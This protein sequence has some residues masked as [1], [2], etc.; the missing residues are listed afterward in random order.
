MSTGTVQSLKLVSLPEKLSWEWIW[1]CDQAA[2]GAQAG[3]SQ[4]S[5]VRWALVAGGIPWFCSP[6]VTWMKSMFMQPENGKLF[7]WSL[8]LVSIS[9]RRCQRLSSWL[10]PLLQLNL[11]SPLP[12][13][14]CQPLGFS[15]E[16]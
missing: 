10:P 5:A 13:P 1:W 11:L 9:L 2:Q 15:I 6:S 3:S 7:L 14:H 12:W 4:G 8:E 16:L